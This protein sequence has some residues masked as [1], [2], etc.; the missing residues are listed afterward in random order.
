MTRAI[1]KRIMFLKYERCTDADPNLSY[2]NSK[3]LNF[4]KM[5]NLH[6][7]KKTSFHYQYF[8]FHTNF[9]NF[10]YSGKFL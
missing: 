2:N 4:K 3:K 10:L 1:Q 6:T 9:D 5:Q 8:R 7:Y